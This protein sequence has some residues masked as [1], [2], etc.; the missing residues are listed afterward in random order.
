MRTLDQIY[1][2]Y[3]VDYKHGGNSGTPKS[4]LRYIEAEIAHK[5]YEPDM[6]EIATFMLSVAGENDWDR[7][8]ELVLHPEYFL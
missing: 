7:E 1:K 5:R 8:N 2:M 3:R 4:F 6:A